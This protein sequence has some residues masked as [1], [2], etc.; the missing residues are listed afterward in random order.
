[1][2]ASHLADCLATLLIVWLHI[3]WQ[4]GWMNCF[5][6]CVDIC[7]VHSW[8]TSWKETYVLGGSAH[9]WFIFCISI[10]MNAQLTAL[11]SSTWYIVHAVP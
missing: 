2:V 4:I 8:L 9:Y 11:S 7:D 3:I 6:V 10:Q 5:T 1:L